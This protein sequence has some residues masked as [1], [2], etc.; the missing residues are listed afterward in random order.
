MRH[1][2]K[3]AAAAFGIALLSGCVSVE[4]T[5]AKLQSGN[6]QLVTEAEKTIVHQAL[7]NHQLSTSESIEY[8][9]LTKNNDVLFDIIRHANSIGEKDSDRIRIA[10][11][12]QVDFSKK[13]VP[14]LFLKECAGSF[15]GSENQDELIRLFLDSASIEDLTDTAYQLAKYRIPSCGGEM[16]CA[17]AKKLALATNSQKLLFDLLA[18]ELRSLISRSDDELAIAKLTV[19]KLTDQGLLMSCACENVFSSYEEGFQKIDEDTVCNFIQND[20]RLS[21]VY[22]RILKKLLARIHDDRKLAKALI[23]RKNS[24]FEPYSDGGGAKA[25]IEELSKRSEIAVAAVASVAKNDEIRKW[26]TDAIKDKTVVKKLIVGDRIDSQA[27]VKLMDKL[28]TGDVDEAMYAAVKDTVVKK[29]LFS[30]LS[31]VVRQKVRG[32]ERAKCEALIA[33]AKKM[34]DKTFVLGGFYLGMPFEQVNMLVGY[35][36]PQWSNSE[37][38]SNDDK[39]LWIPQQKFPFC[40]ADKDGKVYQFDFGRALLKKLCDYDVQDSDEWAQA[41][42]REY[43]INLHEKMLHEERT[44]LFL[45]QTIYSWKNNKKNYRITYFDK[46]KFLPSEYKG[47]ESEFAD[48]SSEEGT[49]R[50]KIEQD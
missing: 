15:S 26:A 12:L 22:N 49:L 13:G 35:Y 34:G 42:S 30:K 16:R 24:G 1:S 6:P 27:K 8:I 41:Y 31:P 36:Q 39:V 10:A 48:I 44:G 32:A 19:A 5:K 25:V 2:I 23:E 46:P 28:E 20:D 17:L 18:G 47:I 50:A 37:G 21:K 4:S 33:E 7:Y 38:N 14:Q 40:R 29:A 3:L 45:T 43:N 9:K 11:A